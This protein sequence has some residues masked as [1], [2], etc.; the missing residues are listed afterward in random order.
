MKLLTL[1]TL[2]FAVITGA[3][4]CSIPSERS[5]WSKNRIVDGTGTVVLAKF[6][7]ATPK[8][9]RFDY[10][11]EVLKILKG[12]VTSKRFVLELDPAPS[13]YVEE[14]FQEHEAPEFW[15]G[16]YGRLPWL[17]GPCTPRYAF[18]A[19]GTYLL[20]IESLNN[21]ASAERINNTTDRWYKFV[22]QR[23]ARIH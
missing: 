19:G 20:F 7:R 4:A 10:H 2:L 23:I 14:T 22:E 11:F 9:A 21:G 13:N 5:N 16:T 8:A 18:E 1:L 3:Q 12:T 17:N 15:E 6:T